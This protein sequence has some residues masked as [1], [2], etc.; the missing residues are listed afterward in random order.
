MIEDV[1]QHNED[2]EI[3]VVEDTEG[4]GGVRGKV[5]DG[6]H[7]VDKETNKREGRLGIQKTTQSVGKLDTGRL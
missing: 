2:N 7:D 3:I 5:P 4:K 6:F 1:N